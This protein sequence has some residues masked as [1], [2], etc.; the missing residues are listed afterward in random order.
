MNWND[1]CD[2]VGSNTDSWLAVQCAQSVTVISL[3]EYTSNTTQIKM[4]DM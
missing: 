4:A 2:F 1:I 3:D